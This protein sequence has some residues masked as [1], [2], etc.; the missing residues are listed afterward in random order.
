MFIETESYKLNV[1]CSL[2]KLSCSIHFSLLP[3][4][5]RVVTY[6]NHYL[7]LPYFTAILLETC[8]LL[9]SFQFILFPSY[10]QIGQLKKFCTYLSTFVI[11]NTLHI[12]KKRF[13]FFQICKSKKMMTA[14]VLGSRARCSHRWID[15]QEKTK[16]AETL[17]L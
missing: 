3:L 12:E 4:C 16:F 10:F 9:P 14:T 7:F 17:K 13:Q 1:K 2:Q 8:L 6:Q 11:L 15:R 5:L